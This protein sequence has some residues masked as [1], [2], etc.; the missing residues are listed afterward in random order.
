M[1]IL[2]AFYKPSHHDHLWYY[3]RRFDVGRL[4]RGRLNRGRL[5]RG[6]LDRGRLDRGWFE[7]DLDRFRLQRLVPLDAIR[8]RSDVCREVRHRPRRSEGWVHAGGV[9]LTP[10]WELCDALVRGQRVRSSIAGFEILLCH[11]RRR[12]WHW[13]VSVHAPSSVCSRAGRWYL[14]IRVACLGLMRGGMLPVLAVV[15]RLVVASVRVW[16]WR[17]EGSR[18]VVVLRLR[19]WS[20]TSGRWRRLVLGLRHSRSSDRL[21]A[22]WLGVKN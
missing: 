12:V 13:I 6:R 2:P 3:R 7:R 18:L 14:I 20:A 15:L 4:D 10:M 22:L 17:D 21:L 16:S 11:G 19:C 9:R 1:G 8:L 5:A